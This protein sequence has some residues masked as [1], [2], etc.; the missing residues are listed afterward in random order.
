MHP[1]AKGLKVDMIDNV[2][3]LL[4]RG[5]FY[6]LDRPNNQVFIEEHKKYQWDKDS[7][8]TSKPK[9]VEVDDHTC[10]MFIYYVND[11]LRKLRL[12]Y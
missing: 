4:A 9:V 6:Y 12:K 1:I 10:D 5:R 7:L 2:H 3:D 11:N 8:E